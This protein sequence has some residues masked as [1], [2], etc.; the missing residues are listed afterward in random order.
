MAEPKPTPNEAKNDLIKLLKTMPDDLPQ[1]LFQ[2]RIKYNVP[3]VRVSAKTPPQ[4]T[5]D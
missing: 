3:I 2:L 4:P 1:M 5:K